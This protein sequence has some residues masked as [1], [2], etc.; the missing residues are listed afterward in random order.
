MT[1]KNEIRYIQLIEVSLF[2]NRRAN[3]GFS[4]PG[5]QAHA[6]PVRVG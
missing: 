2:E 5:T 1:R 3:G 4:L 6:P